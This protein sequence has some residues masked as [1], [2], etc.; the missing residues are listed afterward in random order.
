MHAGSACL[1]L[2]KSPRGP[3]HALIRLAETPPASIASSVTSTGHCEPAASAGPPSPRVQR[4][5]DSN[6]GWFR[7][8]GVGCCAQ[9]SMTVRPRA[10]PSGYFPSTVNASNTL[11]GR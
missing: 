3:T 1:A 6:I 11:P 7:W 5:S 9:A 10:V 4:R 8:R 2:G